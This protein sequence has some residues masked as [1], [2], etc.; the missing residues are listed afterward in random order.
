[1][2]AHPPRALAPYSYLPHPARIAAVV[3]E[4]ADTRTFVLAL[5]PPVAAL[6]GA[7][8]GQFVMLSLLGFGEA[9]FTLSALPGAGG[10][11]RSGECASFRRACSS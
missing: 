10:A 6:D 11:L 9:P 5:E 2:T 7:R 1:M 3:E 8:P 4:S